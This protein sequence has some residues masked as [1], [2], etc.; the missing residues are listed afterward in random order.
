MSD[1][2]LLE[3]AGLTENGHVT[4]A[5]LVLLGTTQAV[6]RLLPQA[7]V[8]FEYRNSDSVIEYQDRVEYRAGFFLWHNE[9][10]EKINARNETHSYRDGMFHYDIPAFN[11][12]VI[13][14]AL[15]NAITHREYRDSRSIFVRQFPTRLEVVSPGGF[16]SGITADNITYRQDPRNRLIAEAL[17][18][19]GLVERSG[20]GA[21]RIFRHC[22]KEGK[23]RPDYTG[24]DDAQV[25][26]V[27]DGEIRDPHFAQYL[28]RL[29]GELNM[30]LALDDILVLDRVRAGEIIPEKL[31]DC[32][33]ALVDRGVIEK[34][35]RGRRVRTSCH[36]PS[37]SMWARQVVPTPAAKG[38]TKGTIRSVSSST[39]GTVAQ[40]A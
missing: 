22:L 33:A 19:C 15:L 2:Q 30:S 21:D 10:W 4:Y 37:T 24:S 11:E 23:N 13:R 6:R 27:L 38:L 16:P 28:N 25:S 36:A 32:F 1:E 18:H 31:K 17:Q 26:L 3:D 34:T 20:Q 12:S 9:I 8:I 40:E 29:A 39:S 5:A 35:G 14:E 7:E